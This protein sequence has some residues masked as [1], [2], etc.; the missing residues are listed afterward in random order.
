MY[1]GGEEE[2]EEEEE[3]GI[4]VHEEGQQKQIGG[5]KHPKITSQLS[6]LP[7]LVTLVLVTNGQQ[8]KQDLIEVA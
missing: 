6:V 1:R 4:G 8:V 7:D 3:G 2:E 5:K